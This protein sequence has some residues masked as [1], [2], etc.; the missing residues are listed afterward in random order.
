MVNASLLDRDLQP[1]T[2]RQTDEET[3]QQNPPSFLLVGGES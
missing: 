3:Q 2:P 1:D